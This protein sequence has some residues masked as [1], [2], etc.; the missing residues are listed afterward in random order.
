[1]TRRLPL[2]GVPD[3]V[4]HAGVRPFLYVAIGTP[5]VVTVIDTDRLV[6]VETIETAPGAHTLGWDPRTR[7][8]YVFAPDRGA[9]L[10]FEEAA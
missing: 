1:M 5:G 4:W 9:A 6:E 2:R 8:L 7:R 10:V 3:V